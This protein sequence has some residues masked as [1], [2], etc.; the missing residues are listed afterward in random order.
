[1]YSVEIAS[2]Q[3]RIAALEAEKAKAEAE[4]DNF[5]AVLDA[6]GYG[7]L[8]AI[9]TQDREMCRVL[10]E[11]VAAMTIARG[12]RADKAEAEL[13]KLADPDA[14]HA[15]MLRG[16]IAKPSWAQIKHLYA[17]EADKAE[18]L[19][20]EAVEVINALV[21]EDCDYMRINNLGDPEKQH[22]IKR[23]RATLAKIKETKN[24]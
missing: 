9:A 14:V 2:L 3:A 16:T 23:A 19:L 5:R 1:M 4:R 21:E 18:A 8:D 22:N 6:A 17:G 12:D 10:G 13:A 11:A 15:N 24:G 7:N 20:A